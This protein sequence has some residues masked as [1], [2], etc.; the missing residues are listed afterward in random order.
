MGLTRSF[1]GPLSKISSSAYYPYLRPPLSAAAVTMATRYA[2]AEI[3]T[4]YFSSFSLNYRLNVMCFCGR[5]LR[6]FKK[7]MKSQGVDCSDALDLVL[8]A[9]SSEV[10]V[11]ALCDLHEGDVVARIP[12]DSCLTIKTS[13]ARQIIEEA[14]LDGYL[15]LA[16]AVMYE[17]S[18]GPLSPWFGYLQLLPYSEP[19]P[20]LWSLS[21]IHSLL[22]GTEL[23]KVTSIFHSLSFSYFY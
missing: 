16:V 7:W 20:L 18:L 1:A 2:T 3:F 9:N 21:E 15:G 5:K 4:H 17:R 19:I 8:T 11:R 13:G 12:K 6:A 14:E 10:S 23:H 22:A